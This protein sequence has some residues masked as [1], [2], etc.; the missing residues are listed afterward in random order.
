MGLFGRKKSAPAKGY[1]GPPIDPDWARNRNGKYFRLIRFDPV[2]EGLRGIGGV[3]VIWHSGV[4]PR[5]VYVAMTNDLAPDMEAAMDRDDIMEYD[6]N[7]GLFIT[8][9]PIKPEFRP[10]VFRYLHENMDTLVPNPEA[11]GV[12]ADPIRVLQP[13][14]RE[15][16]AP[17]DASKPIAPSGEAD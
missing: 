9:S 3:F 12:K 8:W 4:K 10:G 2:V 1:D 17:A 6:I 16:A 13:G 14:R 11:K 5:W 7:G 15:Q